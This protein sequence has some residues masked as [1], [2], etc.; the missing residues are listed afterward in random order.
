MKELKDYLHLYLGCKVE[1]GY[2]ETKRI[3]TLVGKDDLV[4]WQVNTY[5]VL[6]P[7]Q[8][9][10]DELIKPILRPLSDMTEEEF[11]ELS[12]ELSVDVVKSYSLPA[13]YH[14]KPWHVLILENR[15]QTNTLKFNDG[16]VLLR[17]H[18]D[19]FGLIDAGL[20]IAKTK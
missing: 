18:F 4:G 19:L 13:T 6:S 8:Y 10:R 3:G 15:L 2:E 5:K 17:K 7:Y 14:D 11:K 20:A 9:V 16:M 1:Y 12:D